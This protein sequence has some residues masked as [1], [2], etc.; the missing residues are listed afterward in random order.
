MNAELNGHNIEIGLNGARGVGKF[1]TLTSHSITVDAGDTFVELKIDERPG[2]TWVLTCRPDMKPSLQIRSAFSAANCDPLPGRDL[3]LEVC[4][5]L[6][7][8]KELLNNLFS[9]KQWPDEDQL[10][11]HLMSIR[12]AFGI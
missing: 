2:N 10:A 6:L 8:I 1:L 12:G 3:L 4:A 9:N 11:I 5:P 7:C